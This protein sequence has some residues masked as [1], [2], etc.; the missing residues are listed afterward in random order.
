M[1]F[2]YLSSADD[3]E[4]DPC[5]LMY[6]RNFFFFFDRKQVKAETLY[7]KSIL[8][9]STYHSLWKANLPSPNLAHSR[10]PLHWTAPSLGQYKVNF[11]GAISK[12]GQLYGVGVVIYDFMGDFLV[13]LVVN[14][15]VF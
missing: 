4:V 5:C 6:L 2:K 9:L 11:D 13:G 10:E 12:Q 15:R 3:E 1:V 7:P 14:K 8:L